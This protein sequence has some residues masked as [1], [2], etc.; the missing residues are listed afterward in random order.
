LLKNKKFISSNEFGNEIILVNFFA[1]WCKPCREEHKYIIKLS[2]KNNLRIIGINYKDDPKKSIAWLKNL[3]NPY[4]D[5]PLDK[6]GRI[7]IDWGVYGIP[8]T[9]V[10]S[11]DG[12]IEYRH[13]GPLTKKI[14][15][16]IN[17]L[18]STLK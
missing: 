5:V 18:V 3:G 6:N 11:S 16:K 17:L 8:E 7:A 9:F 13:V 12:I 10:I 4:S 2:K 1:T 15:E 14:Y